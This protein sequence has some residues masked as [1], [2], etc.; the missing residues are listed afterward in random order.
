[1]EKD[2]DNLADTLAREMKAPVE[3]AGNEAASIRRVALPWGWTLHEKDDEPYLSAPRRKKATV[4]LHDVDSFVAYVKRHGSLASCTVWCLANYAAGRVGFTSIINDH[5]AE[6]AAQQWRDH[7]ATFAPEFSEEW[8]RWNGRN[9][10]AKAFNQFDFAGFIEENNKDIVSVGGSATGAQMLEMALNMEANQDVKFKSSIRLQ[11]GGVQLNYVAD[12]DH[13][14]ITKMQLFERFT[15]GMP[16]FWNGDAYQVDARL[17]YRVREGKLSFW[18][19]LIRQDKVL[20][21]ATSTMI[22]TIKAQVGM[23]FFFGEP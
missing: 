4:E 8:K 13:Q 22:E 10:P 9:G 20:E 14:T 23:P 6:P 21:A 2:Q 3:I 12:D 1:M 17:R 7:T 19:E 5:G 15:L 11:G 16:V 18:Y